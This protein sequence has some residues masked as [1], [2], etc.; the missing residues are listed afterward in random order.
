MDFIDEIGDD[1]RLVKIEVEFFYRLAVA[2]SNLG[3]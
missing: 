1:I 2:F 3:I